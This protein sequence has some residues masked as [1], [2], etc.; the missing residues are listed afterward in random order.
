[1]NDEICPV[2]IVVSA[3]WNQVGRSAPIGCCP[4]KR[5]MFARRTWLAVIRA[6]GTR[7]LAALGGFCPKNDPFAAIVSH[8][9]DP[10]Q[11]T[12]SLLMMCGRT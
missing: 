4:A 5:G 1:M 2:G 10:W 6:V 3:L 8:P 11:T 7:I 12:I 9:L